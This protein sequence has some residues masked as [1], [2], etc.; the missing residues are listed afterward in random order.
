MF[1]NHLVYIFSIMLYENLNMTIL[2]CFENVMCLQGSYILTI[3]KEDEWKEDWLLF[4]YLNGIKL[5]K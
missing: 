3:R 4:S 5:Y 1:A 2:K